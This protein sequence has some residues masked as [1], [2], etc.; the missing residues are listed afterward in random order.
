M[1]INEND[2]VKRI[3]ACEGKIKQVNIGQIREVT[4]LLLDDLSQL[5]PSDVLVLIEKHGRRLEKSRK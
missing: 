4:R 2:L 3:A 1:A 5:H